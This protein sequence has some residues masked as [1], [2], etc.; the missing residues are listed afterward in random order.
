MKARKCITFILFA[1]AVLFALTLSAFAE[2]APLTVYV[3]NSGSDDNSGASSDTPVKTMSK[4]YARLNALMVEAGLSNDPDAVGHI[5][6]TD[7]V[8]FKSTNGPTPSA[9]DSHVY[10]VAVSGITPGVQMQIKNDYIH[11]GP[12]KYENITLKHLDNTTTN[13]SFFVANGYPLTIGENVTVL[14]DSSG[15]YFT[16]IGALRSGAYTGDTRLTVSSGTWRNIYAGSY[17]DDMTGDVYLTMTGGTVTTTVASSYSHAHTGNFYADVSNAHIRKISG[18]NTN[19]SDKAKGN[20]VI[21]LSGTDVSGDI[22]GGGLNGVTGDVTVSISDCAVKG[23][24]TAVCSGKANIILDASFGKR[25]EFQKG[26]INASAF[27]G[28]G[29]LV[30]SGDAR[31]TLGSV[32]GTTSL[33]LLGDLYNGIPYITAPEGAPDGAFAYLPQGAETLYTKTAGG[34]KQWLISGGEDPVSLIIS[35]PQDT[36]FTLYNGFKRTGGAVAP[37]ETSTDG[38]ATLY[39]YFLLPVGDYSY[40]CCGTGYYKVTRNFYYSEEKAAHD[41]YLDADPGKKTNAGFEPDEEVY[42]YTQ[43]AVENILPSSPALWPDYAEVFKTPYFAPGHPENRGTSQDEMTSFIRSLDGEDDNMYLYVIGKTPSYGYDYPVV[44]FTKA[45]LSGAATIEEAAAIIKADG[46]TTVHYQGQIHS[47]EPAG[48]ESALALIRTLDGDYGESVLDSLDIYVV[49]R[50]NPDGARDYVRRNV[51]NG[52]DMNRDHLFMQSPETAMLHRVYNLFL[53]E[54]TIDAH[55]FNGPMDKDSFAVD[56]VQIGIAHNL[57]LSDAKND[58][59]MAVANKCFIDVQNLGLRAYY[60]T[61]NNPYISSSNYAIGREYF[62]LAGSLSFLIETNGLY[63]GF[64]WFA[65]RVM[66]QYAVAESIIDYV[67]K[68]GQA[69][70]DAVAQYR[71]EVAEK[72]AAYDEDDLLV[73][74]HDTSKTPVYALRPKWDLQNGTLSDAEATG[75]MNQKDKAVTARVRPT[76][77]VIPKDAPGAD[78]AAALIQKHGIY[79][80]EINSGFSAY[81]RQYSGSSALAELLP[82][83]A[84]TFENGAYVF[85]MD[86]GA[87]NIL[88]VLLEPDVGDTKG[89]NGTLMQSGIIKAGGDGTIPIYRCVRDLENGKITLE[90]HS[91]S[92][93]N[94][95]CAVC[96]EDSVAVTLSDGVFTLSGGLANGTRVFAAGYKDGRFVSAKELIWKGEPLSFAAPLWESAAVFFPGDGGA[97]LRGCIKTN[98]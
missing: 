13:H 41:L 33:Q 71:A 11:L 30:L 59:S 93:E 7:T 87:G 50:V 77:Y 44:I 64:G 57:N 86:Q 62:G 61:G 45:D 74:K 51:K 17:L 52:V 78:R 36:T 4:A 69:V 72:G 15:Y 66:S 12:T 92:F 84:V 22:V 31:L 80:Y 25:L 8:A 81:L 96:G 49:P 42:Y 79:Y 47:N 27:S 2:S 53:P 38:G 1:A 14:P 70:R 34:K 20:V 97:P 5:V 43:E 98:Y 48:G 90:S 76:A 82:E 63:S 28:G 83:K 39:R 75:T 21:S 73:L 60:Y 18:A 19:G 54:V 68:N 88:A 32:T 35:A 23:S 67:V 94:G 24:V 26:E 29:A 58:I 55:E 56:D 91:H 9:F 46:K 95:I 65:R 10:T 89:Y 16:I 40:T 6:L 85:P 3:G 37:S